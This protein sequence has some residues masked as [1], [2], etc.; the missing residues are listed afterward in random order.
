MTHDVIVIGAGVSGLV[1]AEHAARSGQR[2]LVLEKAARVGGCLVSW[3]AEPGY[4][5]ELGA[6]TA[7]NSYGALLEVLERRGRLGELLRREKAGYHFLE[8]GALRSP[9]AR[10]NWPSLLASLP[11]GLFK[12][13]SGLSVRDY[14]GALF[15]ADNYARVL[16]PAFAAVLSQPCD[17]YP[18]DWLFRRKPRLKSAPRKYSWA[19]GMQ[20]LLE[21]VATDAPFEIRTGADARA[22]TRDA[23]GYRIELDGET[24]ACSTLALA[25]PPDV[26]SALL[27]RVAPDVSELL[28]RFPMA[29]IESCAVTVARDATRLPKLAGLIGIDD[30]FYS[31]VSRDPVA[32]PGRRAFTFHFRPGRYGLEAKRR[33]I[34]EVLGCAEGDF[35]ALHEHPNRL[36][37][38]DTRHPALVGKIEEACVGRRLALLGNYFQGMSIGDCAERAAREAHRLFV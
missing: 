33:R 10:L 25:T 1:F 4:Y 19:T 24:L 7:Y 30:A 32:H 26:A 9:L 2:V 21:A 29:D 17:D 5:V 15:G 16:G 18:A 12:D 36:P 34:A 22:V 23:S 6:H 31:V 35:L 27:A 8:D 13:K 3:Q 37:S 14:Y 11:R 28:E 20:G 38:L